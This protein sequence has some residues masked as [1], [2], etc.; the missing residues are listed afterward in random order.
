MYETRV[1]KRER[2]RRFCVTRMDL[3]LLSSFNNSEESL[4]GFTLCRKLAEEGS[5][6]YV[7]TT[8]T[9]DILQREIE[10][11]D[12]NNSK[13]KG[14]ITLLQPECEENEIP[15]AEWI[16]KY[17]RKYFPFLQELTDIQTV[18][19]LISKTEEAAIE[20]KGILKCKL[21]LLAFTKIQANEKYFHRLFDQADQTWALG[22]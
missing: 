17:H 19:G 9:G 14:D 3:V 6:L 21:S 5:Q 20:L 1:L 18:I 10:K 13:S 7:T 12:E 15:D 22:S 4:V 8:S 2:F 11:I 16:I